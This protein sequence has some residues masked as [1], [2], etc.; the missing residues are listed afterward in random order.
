M[1]SGEGV[2]F[3]LITFAVIAWC[4]VTRPS[5]VRCPDGFY[6]EGVRPSG[7][8]TCRRPTATAPGFGARIYCTGGA[9]PVVDDRDGRT[10]G[11]QRSVP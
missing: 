3:L 9:I 1:T 11:C 6:A 8:T 4:S 7:E 10:V 5:S 2:V